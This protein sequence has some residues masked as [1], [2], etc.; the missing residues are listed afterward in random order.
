MRGIRGVLVDLD[1]TL[2]DTAIVNAKAYASALAE[3]GVHIDVM[4]LS[5]IASGRNWRQFL[6]PLL[7]AAKVDAEPAAIAARKSIHYSEMIRDVEI[8]T[9]LVMLLNTCRPSVKTAL[10]TTASG[11]N[12]RAIMDCHGLESL[13]DVV[14][15]GDEVARHK[16]DPEAYIVAADRL[17]LSPKECLAFEDSEIGVASARAAGIA[18]I[19]VIFTSDPAGSF[20]ING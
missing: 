16:P 6:P 1:G 17:N 9:P 19:R 4:Q 3:V 7:A 14:V 2:A 12:A 5:Q 11:I 13:F 8:N 18:V 20:R 15:T 10:V